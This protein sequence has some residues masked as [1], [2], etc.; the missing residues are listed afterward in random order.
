MPH[1]GPGPPAPQE[2]SARLACLRQRIPLGQFSQNPPSPGC[3]VSSQWRPLHWPR[4][5]PGCELPLAQV[6]CETPLRRPWT[7]P[8]CSSSIS[9]TDQVFLD[10]HVYTAV[11]A[12]VG[13][14]HQATPR[15]LRPRVWTRVAWRMPL[16]FE[17]IESGSST[18]ALEDLNSLV[19]ST[20]HVRYRQ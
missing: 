1:Q 16:L 7:N 11:C 2:E 4:P 14:A 3:D 10:A 19:I 17:A 12:G 15:T 9:V 6:N 18:E 13:G 8:A 20:T 5:T